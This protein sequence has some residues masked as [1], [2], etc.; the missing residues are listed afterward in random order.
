MS[1]LHGTTFKTR[2]N[3]MQ[4]KINSNNTRVLKLKTKL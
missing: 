3:P 2:L 1:R 4:E